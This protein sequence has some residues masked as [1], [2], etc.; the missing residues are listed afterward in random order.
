MAAELTAICIVQLLSRGEQHF[1]NHPTDTPA[2]PSGTL[3]SRVAGSSRTSSTVSTMSSPPPKVFESRPL[4]PLPPLQSTQRVDKPPL[5]RNTIDQ[6]S[7]SQTP[8]HLAQPPASSPPSPLPLPRRFDTVEP[9]H[10]RP[11]PKAS[12]P[13]TVEGAWECRGEEHI[14]MEFQVEWC[15]FRRAGRQDAENMGQCDFRIFEHGR[16]DSLPTRRIAFRSC[17]H[18]EQCICFCE[19]PRN[20]DVLQHAHCTFA[21][22]PLDN[23]H[24]GT[25]HGKVTVSWSDCSHIH[26]ARKDYRT[27][28]I[29]VSQW[30]SSVEHRTNMG[31]QRYIPTKHNRR[32]QFESKDISGYS[33]YPT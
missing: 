9:V 4:T 20:I 27:T 30:D 26:E 10:L 7:T 22:M 6:P 33:A 19:A 11:A 31:S 21:G 28:F 15:S 5:R 32:L 14:L 16:D 12:S 2:A 1:W 8:P 18:E 13:S 24:V 23:V 17:E 25:E 3:A 29:C